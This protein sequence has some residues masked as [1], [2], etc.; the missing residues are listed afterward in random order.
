[1]VKCLGKLKDAWKSESEATDEWYTSVDDAIDYFV[2]CFKPATEPD[3]PG[4]E[5]DNVNQAPG[6]GAAPG[7]VGS[8]LQR[9][10]R[11]ARAGTKGQ[12]LRF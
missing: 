3:L 8:K 6:A 9:G 7:G 1:M 12:G 10:G 11:V 4:A 2:G 5:R